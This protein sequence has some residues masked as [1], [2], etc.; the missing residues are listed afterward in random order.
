MDKN[1]IKIKELEAKVEEYRKE[2]QKQ[3]D[4]KTELTNALA[5]ILFHL[6][7]AVYHLPDWTDFPLKIDLEVLK[8]KIPTY[9][10]NTLISK[11]TPK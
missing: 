2:A 5:S 11:L 9:R 4:H 6:N 3:Y 8:D 10:E 7:N 1:D